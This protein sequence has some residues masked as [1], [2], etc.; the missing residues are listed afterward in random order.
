[1]PPRGKTE[2]GIINEY[3]YIDKAFHYIGS[4]NGMTGLNGNC[5][6]SF[7]MKYVCLSAHEYVLLFLPIKYNDSSVYRILSKE[8][9]EN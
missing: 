5:M 3:C 2:G 9:N 4:A 1:M 7:L 6:Q 8:C